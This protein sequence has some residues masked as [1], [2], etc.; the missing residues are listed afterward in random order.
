MIVLNSDYII[1]HD[2]NKIL[3]FIGTTHVGQELY[4]SFNATRR[5][6][7][8]QYE[9]IL[10]KDQQWVD[11]R[12]FIVPATTIAFKKMVVDG[13]EKFN[14]D[15]FTVCSPQAKIG[16]GVSIGRGSVVNAF[17]QIT[18]R[19]QIGNHAIVTHFV[20]IGHKS[21]VGDFGHLSPYSQLLNSTLG[22]GCFLSGKTSV[23]GKHDSP[24]IIAPY[25]TF[26]FGSTVTKSISASGTFYDNRKIN[27]LTSLENKID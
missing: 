1:L 2:K 18:T 6:E 16:P 4:Q 25:C 5:C 21:V 8:V 27:N 24:V 15:Y 20:H 23:I 13:L 22:E 19:V 3:C 9:E 11:E 26:L 12:Q 10:N 17:N 7:Q 14:P